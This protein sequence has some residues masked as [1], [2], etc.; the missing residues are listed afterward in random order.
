MF[1]LPTSTLTWPARMFSNTLRNMV[2]SPRPQM[3]LGRMEHVSMPSTP[4]CDST[5]FSAATLVS[6][7]RSLKRAV[8][9]MVSS[10]FWMSCPPMTT[11]FDAV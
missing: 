11:L 9:G 2:W 4:F 6:V 8:Y 3:P 1:L 10:P 7:Y 5:N